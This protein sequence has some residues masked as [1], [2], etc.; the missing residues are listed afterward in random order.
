MHALLI[1]QLRFREVMQTKLR[2]TLWNLNEL[3]RTYRPKDR[4]MATEA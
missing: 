3:V 1:L 2:F 4:L